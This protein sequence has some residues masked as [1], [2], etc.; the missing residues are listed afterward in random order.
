MRAFVPCKCCIPNTADPASYVHKFQAPQR[1]SLPATETQAGVTGTGRC[2]PIVLSVALAVAALAKG[3]IAAG[4]I[5]CLSNAFQALWPAKKT[6]HEDDCLFWQCA[7][8]ILRTLGSV[9]YLDQL[10]V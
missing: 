3:Q 1:K 4:D 6:A 5:R 2:H 10:Y 8:E 9:K 7:C